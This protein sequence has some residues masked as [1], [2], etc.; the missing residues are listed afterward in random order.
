MVGKVWLG[1]LCL[2]FVSPGS[3]AADVTLVR[4]EKVAEQ[5]IGAEVLTEIYSK[6]GFTVAIIPTTAARAGQLTLD[7]EVDGGVDAQALRYGSYGIAVSSMIRVEPP[8]YSVTTTAFARRGRGLSI[9]S[10]DDLRSYRVGIVL[11]AIHTNAQAAGALE[12][13]NVPDT[14]LL[15]KM[16]QEGRIDIALDTKIDGDYLVK[17]LRLGDIVAV[18]DLAKID[19]F[20]YLTP[21]NASLARRIGETIAALQTAGQ[22]DGLVR[23]YERA[24][25]EGGVRPDL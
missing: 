18:G 22:L 7:G 3:R 2:L 19:I 9:R 5:Y 13:V 23:R 1:A 6:A 11:S 17:A 12:I 14:Y 24:L 8:Y 10:S 25:V 4:I 16:L 21:N 15:F 20:N